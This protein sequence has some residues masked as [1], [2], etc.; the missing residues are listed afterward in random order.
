MEIGDIVHL[1]GLKAEYSLYGKDRFTTCTLPDGNYVIVAIEDAYIKL[2]W[3]DL[4]GYPSR[5][6]RYRVEKAI[7]RGIHEA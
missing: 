5:K 3:R 1:D 4:T 6:H 2:A 7:I